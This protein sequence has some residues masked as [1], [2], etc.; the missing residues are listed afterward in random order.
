MSSCS[1]LQNERVIRALFCVIRALKALFVCI[2]RALRA[3]FC[4]LLGLLGL[5]L[6]VIRALRAFFVCY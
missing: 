3:L 4:V 1:C 2:I 6:C 5:F